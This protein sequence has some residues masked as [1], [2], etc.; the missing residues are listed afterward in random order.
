MSQ[1]KLDGLSRVVGS[2]R[3]LPRWAQIA[4]PALAAGVLAISGYAVYAATAVVE[5]NA[6]LL[7][8]K[9]EAS[10]DAES[11]RATGSENSKTI[12]KLRGEV[13]EYES[14]QAALEE[15]AVLLT[16]REEVVTAREVAVTGA[17]AAKKA[18]EFSGGTHMIGTDIQPGTYS[19][20]GSS[21]CYWERLRGLGGG[22]GDI[23]AN[24]IP[25]GQA[26]VTIPA[27]D[28]AFKSSGCGTWTKIG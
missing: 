20:P 10:A 22:L 14:Q 15:A 24:A 11:A 2:F 5:S 9:A 4:L 23:I 18:N 25:E 21:S 3:Q 8:L 12:L 27:S 7:E 16:E 19:T 26:V 6:H 28:V 17:E 1:S 13:A